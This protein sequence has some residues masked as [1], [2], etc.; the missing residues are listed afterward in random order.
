MLCS[1]ADLRGQP[2]IVKF[3]YAT[4]VSEREPGKSKMAQLERAF[5][6][7]PLGD[8]PE[9][10]HWS[11]EEFFWHGVPGD[12]WH[13]LEAYLAFVSDRLSEPARE[14]LRL[15]KE[16]QVGLWRIEGVKS[17]TVVLREWDPVREAPAGERIRAISLGM[18]GADFYRQYQGH[19]LLT[20]MSPW[21]PDAGIYCTMGYGIMPNTDELGP[22]ELLL[23][24]R[25]PDLVAQPLPWKVSQT[26]AR[27]YLRTWKRRDWQSWLEER[28]EFPFR[29]LVAGVA[30]TLTATEVT[31]IY[32]Q[33]ADSAREFG[34]YLE[35]PMGKGIQ[36]VGVTNLM[37]MGI[38]TPTWMAIKEYH[39]YRERV[40]PPPGMRGAPRVMRLR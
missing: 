2:D 33:D 29:A 19:L 30:D 36:M 20:Y 27:E 14:Q 6:R 8:I 7:G 32:H 23:A 40:G 12:D 10:D 3:R 26:A 22:T 9:I 28:L 37:P 39:V 38:A 11:M 13:P 31:G 35:A 18:G 4:Y 25:R 15:W 5:K 34:I 24:L 17:K 16:A 1:D 21:L